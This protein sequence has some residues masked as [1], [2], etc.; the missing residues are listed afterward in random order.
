VAGYAEENR[1]NRFKLQVYLVRI[2]RDLNHHGWRSVRT[3]QVTCSF[4]FLMRTGHLG[5]I[6]GVGVD[7]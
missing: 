5:W 2:D 4:F 6:H 3:G 7:D 1:I